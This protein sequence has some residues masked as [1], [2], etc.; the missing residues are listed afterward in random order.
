MNI[1]NRAEIARRRIDN[2]PNSCYNTITNE[3]QAAEGLKPRRNGVYTM[4]R[5]FDNFD[6][7]SEHY[8]EHEHRPPAQSA[9]RPAGCARVF[10]GDFLHRR[11]TP[12]KSRVYGAFISRA[13]RYT[14]KARTRV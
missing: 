7:Y 9:H 2:S 4:T 11:E 10:R 5:H 1:R 14:P 13:Y 12:P 3:K 8:N 6:Q